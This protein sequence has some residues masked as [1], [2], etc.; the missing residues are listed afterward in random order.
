[1]RV[2]PSVS[3]LE[4]ALIIL[5][6]YQDSQDFRACRLHRAY[7]IPLMMT[8]VNP[9]RTLLRMHFHGELPRFQ[10]CSVAFTVSVA[11]FVFSRASTMCLSFSHLDMQPYC[12]M[13]RTRCI[14][15][16][17]GVPYFSLG[18]LPF[19]FLWFRCNFH[20]SVSSPCR[21]GHS[22]GHSKTYLLNHRNCFSTQAL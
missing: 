14:S 17:R 20:K 16:K 2:F 3:S 4:S 7:R 15:R 5:L 6:G 18:P 13:H 1:M 8:W 19:F 10:A 11:D 21:G 12:S 22:C 9:Q